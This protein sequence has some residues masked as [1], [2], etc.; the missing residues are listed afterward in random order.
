MG[1]R[2]LGERSSQPTETRDGSSESPGSQP[3]DPG[4]W[5][6]AL[7]QPQ[8][9]QAAKHLHNNYSVNIRAHSWR[10]ALLLP[11]PF[12]VEGHGED[13]SR[14]WPL[15]GV[16]GEEVHRE[17]GLHHYGAVGPGTRAAYA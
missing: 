9:G 11:P 4:W 17:A 8:A 7:C 15:V 5:W 14:V 13:L 12:L 10:P 2:L 6:G 3:P 16:S 1:R